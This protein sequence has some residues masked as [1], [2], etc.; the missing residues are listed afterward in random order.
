M[1]NITLSAQDGTIDALRRIAQ[2]KHT[3]V[4]DLFR[5][6]ADQLAASEQQERIKKFHDTLKQTSYVQLDHKFTREEMNQR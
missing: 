2:A 5:E 6:W 3:T 1:K 4:N